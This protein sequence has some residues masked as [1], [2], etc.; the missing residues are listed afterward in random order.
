MKQTTGYGTRAATRASS[1]LAKLSRPKIFGALPRERLF[2]ALDEHRAH[3]IVWVGGPPGA[4]K[5]TLVASYLEAR[6][7]PGIWYHVDS[8]D[9]DPAT[10]F[11]YLGLAGAEAAPGEHQSLPLLTPEY[12]ADLS[13]FSRRFFRELYRRLPRP[14]AL[15][16]D[17]GQEV[18]GASALHALLVDSACEIPEGLNVILIS[19]G[20]PPSLYTRLLANRTLA[21]LDWHDL[22]LTAEEARCIASALSSDEG[23]IDTL[24]RQSDGW[25]AGLTLMLERLRRNGIAPGRLEAETREAVFNYFAGEIL[26]RATPEDQHILVSTAFL[27]SMTGAVA[28]QVSG[29]PR[30][31]QLLH[32]LYRGQLFT[33]CRAG[34]PPCFQYHDLFRQFLLARAEA[35]YHPDELKDIARRAAALLEEHGDLEQAFAL[36]ARCE[37]WDAA[38]DLI[39]K[40]AERLLAQGRGQTLRE[41]IDALSE[42]QA[43]VTPWLDYW[44]GASLIQV[45]Q[46]DARAA[47]ERAWD[48]FKAA[49]DQSGQRLVAAGI[50]ETYLHEW[51]T[52][53][54]MDPWI[55]VLDTLIDPDTVFPSRDA[56]LR[57]YSGLLMALVKA[58]PEHRLFSV[59]L[60]RL[61]VLL[62]DELDINQRICAA[63]LLL[64]VHCVNLDVDA[65]RA[66][67]GQLEALLRHGDAAPLVRLFAL[68]QIALS[69]WLEHNHAQAALTLQEAMVVAEGHGL[70]TADPFLYFA[71]HLLAVAR[72]DGAAVESNIQELRHNLD[73]TRKLGLAVL[74]RALA[75]HAVLEGNEA[76]AI[77]HGETAVSL[78]DEAAARPLQSMW[79]VALTAALLKAGRYDEAAR[80]LG[81]ARSVIRGTSFQ[82]ALRDHD[83]LQAL[84]CLRRSDRP[85]CH[86]LF[87]QALAA[88]K[89]GRAA[90][91]VFVL[92]PGFLSELC[93]EALRSGLAVE[94]VKRFIT[95][96]QLAPPSAADDTWPWPIKIYSLGHFAVLKDGAPMRFARR[97]QK[98][99]LELLQALIAFGG[100]EVGV[101]TLTEALWPDS[102]GDTAYHAFESVLYR[103]RQLLGSA[104]A[105]TLVGGKLSLDT[106]SCWVDVWAFERYLDA[107]RPDGV[108]PEQSLERLRLL[109]RGHF[110]EQESEKSW[111]LATREALR[112]K[113]LLRIQSVAASHETAKRWHEAAAIYQRGIELDNLAEGL[114]R[115]LMVCHRELGNHAEGLKTYRRCRELLSVVLG[116]QPTA[117]TQAVYQS[118]KQNSVEGIFLDRINAEQG[119][120]RIE[121]TRAISP[122]KISW[123][124]QTSPAMAEGA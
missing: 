17:D 58:R 117:R 95:E 66:L 15:V 73:P 106:R 8:G 18:L 26:D 107:A 7:L 109:Y 123:T 85:G 5:T 60:D 78:A 114:Y 104:G 70:K 53:A 59:C 119:G 36:Y 111:A 38:T 69:L 92:Y 31:S 112:E 11:Y 12:L 102:E 29:S 22:R 113:F 93:S 54:P 115:G 101:S 49:G 105:L 84:V 97:T 110:L 35:M 94:Q 10:F 33:N 56:E 45:H 13:G 14:A 48:G 71:R 91:Q 51:S 83:L 19:R 40:Q 27:P 76:G 72:S 81:E 55:D 96:Y 1:T 50:I 82:G 2:R 21:L 80:R 124:P 120:A 25:A 86:R 52:F 32:Q 34:T 87:A 67:R 61:K 89:P 64:C 42:R 122:R 116:V 37:N 46:P 47:L 65:A 4:G 3:P 57:I 103:L 90:S 39:L 121:K 6:Q 77:E 24:Y 41:W 44:Y 79:R 20:E 99:P 30:A 88:P 74:S 100:I 16:L 23:L 63:R 118:L 9:S 98:R 108:S 62:K 75:D 43:A 28:E 68:R